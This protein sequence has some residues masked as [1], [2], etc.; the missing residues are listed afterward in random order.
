M[1]AAPA[2]Y[3]FARGLRRKGMTL[4]CFVLATTII[5]GIAAYVD[6]Y[7]VHEWATTTDVGPFALQVGVS[8]TYYEPTLPNMVSTIR[9]LPGIERAAYIESSF[10]VLS[11]GNESSYN[12]YGGNIVEL[13]SDF[14]S[15]FPE[16]YQFLQGRLPRNASEIAVHVDVVEWL[17]IGIGDTLNC[18]VYPYSSVLKVIGIY[19]TPGVKATQSSYYYFLGN[20]LVNNTLLGQNMQPEVL[21]DVD[22]TP[23][24]PYDASASLN[25]ASSRMIVR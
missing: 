3:E 8:E 22:R 23:L 9:G 24:T 7:S 25:S 5:M 11:T 19:T 18:S 14:V 20:A 4:A 16:A 21:I 2:D 13:S 6:S 17:H 15:V 1:A 12:Q 10:A